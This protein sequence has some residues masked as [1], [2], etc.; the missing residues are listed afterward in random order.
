MHAAAVIVADRERRTPLMRGN[1]NTITST[2]TQYEF[3]I[4]ESV[5]LL[6]VDFLGLSTLSV[7]AG[8]PPDL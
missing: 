8:G 1:K 6:K 2:I 3:P 4:L 7:I 5:R